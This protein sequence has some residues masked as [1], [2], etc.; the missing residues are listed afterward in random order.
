MDWRIGAPVAPRCNDECG[1]A[2]GRAPR[3]GLYFEMGFAKEQE[4]VWCIECY[5]M[6]KTIHENQ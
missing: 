6:H 5:E 4:T 3:R 2:Y 1:H